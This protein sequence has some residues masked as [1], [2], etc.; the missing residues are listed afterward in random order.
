MRLFKRSYAKRRERARLRMLRRSCGG[1][2]LGWFLE[3]R[4]VRLARLTEPQYA[5]MFW[6][7]YRVTPMPGISWETLANSNLW[8]TSA[9]NRFRNAATGDAAQ[10]AFQGGRLPIGLT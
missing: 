10:D 9:A 1:R 2:E 5:E 3:R 6:V 8:V 4:G 7:Q